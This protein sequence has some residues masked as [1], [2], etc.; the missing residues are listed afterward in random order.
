M[1]PHGAYQNAALWLELI[2][3]PPRSPP[4][5]NPNKGCVLGR[6]AVCV[7]AAAL[8]SRVTPQNM[9][10]PPPPGHV[11]NKLPYFT[12]SCSLWSF[13]ETWV[14]IPHPGVLLNKC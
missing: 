10:R 13:L 4:P 9:L 8:T 14:P 1:S 6:H 12:F 2:I 5:L 11:S 3:Q 7:P